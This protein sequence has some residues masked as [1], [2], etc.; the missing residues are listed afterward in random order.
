M[1]RQLGPGIS[2][3][4]AGSLTS[5]L[6][7]LVALP[8]KLHWNRPLSLNQPKQL[9]QNQKNSANPLNA[10]HPRFGCLSLDPLSPSFADRGTLRRGTRG[11]S[12]GLDVLTGGAGSSHFY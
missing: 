3:S 6:P 2:R 7:Q 1:R 11:I 4:R 9:H 8:H 10:Q 5:I 12:H